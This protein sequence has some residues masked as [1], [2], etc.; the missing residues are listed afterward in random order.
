M[1][2][3]WQLLSSAYLQISHTIQ[4]WEGYFKMYLVQMPNYQV[5]MDT[6]YFFSYI[7]CADIWEKSVE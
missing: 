6:E 4:K 5:Q 3:M 7:F 2:C 1:Y